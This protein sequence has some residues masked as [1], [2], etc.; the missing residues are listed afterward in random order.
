MRTLPESSGYIIQ[1]LVNNIY[2]VVSPWLAVVC[3]VKNLSKKEDV[4]NS[5]SFSSCSKDLAIENPD[6][7]YELTEN[8]GSNT[9]LRN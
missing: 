8:K 4:S 7:C 5:N 9:K 2:K 6:R 1:M 3:E